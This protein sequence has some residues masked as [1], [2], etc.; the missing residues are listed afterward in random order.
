MGVAIFAKETHGILHSELP[1]MSAAGLD[2]WAAL[3]FG[4]L[5]NTREL[6]VGGRLLV[7]CSSLWSAWNSHGAAGFSVERG[8]LC[9]EL[10][11][12]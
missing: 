6:L 12:C 7:P 11:V 1:T 4:G 3:Q 9:S 2:A 5:T 8:R 10:P